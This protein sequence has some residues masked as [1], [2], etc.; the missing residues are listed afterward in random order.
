MR[1]VSIGSYKLSPMARN[2]PRMN[3]KPT[4]QSPSLAE[5]T[6]LVDPNDPSRWADGTCRSLGNAF[7]SWRAQ[8]DWT[9]LQRHVENGAKIT[10]I[11]SRRD[12]SALRSDTNRLFNTS[13]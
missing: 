13:A 11:R 10:E 2:E 12:E 8:V 9:Q 7:T 5:A 3:R 6:T 4:S 1:S